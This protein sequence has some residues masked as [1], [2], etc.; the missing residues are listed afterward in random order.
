[1]TRRHR[2][3]KYVALS[4]GFWRDHDLQ[5]LTLADRGLFIK[6]LSYCGD[7]QNDGV[8][9]ERDWALVVAGEVPGDIPGS[10]LALVHA[11][12]LRPND[13]GG[14]DIPS[15]T[16]WNMSREEI[17]SKRKAEREKKAKQ[18]KRTAN[19][20]NSRLSPGTGG[21]DTQGDVPPD[22]MPLDQQINRSIEVGSNSV[23]ENTRALGALVLAD[24]SHFGES[25]AA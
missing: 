9:T 10:V 21:G 2:K 6:A 13:A 5:S 25:G 20:P 24:E 22:V 11:G 12:V 17:E 7:V 16:E 3:D 15:Y 8:M 14:Y 18:R 19:T 4:V 1:M 23:G